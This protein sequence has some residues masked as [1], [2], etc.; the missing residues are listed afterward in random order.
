M[1]KTRL[2]HTRRKELWFNIQFWLL[3]FLYEW[4]GNAAV[5]DEYR[6]Y[7]I[8]ASVIVPLTLLSALFTVHV[9]IKELY[10][11]NR[12][13]L[14]WVCL[15]ASMFVFV[16][17]RR[18]F[19]YYYTYPHYY[20]EAQKNTPLLFWPKLLIEGVYNYLIVALYALF[21]FIKAWYQQQRIALALQQDKVQSE[22]ELLKA[23]VH[24]HFIFNTLNNIYSLSLRQHP[25][26]PHLIYRLSSFL[27]YNLYD[28]KSVS[29]PLAKELDYIFNYIE[30]EKIRYG[31]KL[32]VS[33]NIYD[34]LEGF[35]ICPLLLMPLVENCF[36]HGS[37]P[38]PET[39]WIRMDI[40]THRDWVTI[41]LEN[42]FCAEERKENGRSGI[43]LENVRRRLAILF[44]GRHELSFFSEN[45]S[46]LVILKLKS[47]QYENKMPVG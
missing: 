31:E 19:N 22:L 4:I 16:L 46:Y 8:N 34:S 13:Q 37:Q 23:Q 18:S 24:P 42:S 36:K 10:M 7:F 9:L 20:P 40:N 12:K 30:L 35:T 39:A 38:G 47:Y 26:T 15:V 27:D 41:K 17:A 45:N 3:Y 28:S 21:Y 29:I 43:G 11:K 14:F 5:A 6:R 44:P 32:D 33:I 2:M 1:H 25:Q